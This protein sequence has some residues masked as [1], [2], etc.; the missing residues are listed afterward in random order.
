M[1]ILVT[2]RFGPVPFVTP[3][4]DRGAQVIS[5]RRAATQ[6]IL[7]VLAHRAPIHLDPGVKPRDDKERRTP[8][9]P[10]ERMFWWGAG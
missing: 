8:G 2:P 7:S 4:L 1:Q 5:S 3:R 6:I 9:P 10:Q